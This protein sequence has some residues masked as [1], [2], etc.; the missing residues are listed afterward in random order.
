MT[1]NR[2]GNDW[3]RMEEVRIMKELKK[4]EMKL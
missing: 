1:N 2:Y 4:Q 3:R